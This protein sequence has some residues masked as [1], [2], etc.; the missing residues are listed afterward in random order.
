[1]GNS[2]CPPCQHDHHAAAESVRGPYY[3]IVGASLR[4][5]N[6]AEGEMKTCMDGHMKTITSAMLQIPKCQDANVHDGGLT[7]CLK[8]SLSLSEKRRGMEECR[9]AV[10]DYLRDP[11]PVT[12]LSQPEGEMSVNRLCS[13]LFG[14]R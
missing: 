11:N 3:D 4:Q 13:Y 9:S 10:A 2:P 6:C 7:Q 14:Q 5:S 1:M 8:T 12:T